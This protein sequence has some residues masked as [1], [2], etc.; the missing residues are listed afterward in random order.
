MKVTINKI[1]EINRIYDLGYNMIAVS[2]KMGLSKSTI[3]NYIQKPRNRGT[4]GIKI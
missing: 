2:K 1:I 4:I 3:C